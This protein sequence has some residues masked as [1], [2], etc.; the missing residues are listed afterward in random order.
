VDEV[1]NLLAQGVPRDA[2][3]F[4]ALGYRHVLANLDNKG[5]WEDT[6]RVI[7][8]DTR[9]YAKRQLTWFRR[10]TNTTW[11]G[12]TGNNKSIQEEVHRRVQLFVGEFYGV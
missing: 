1:R 2:K 11:F 6:I 4:G 12:G 10:Q 5:A 9:R 8:R 7:Q 3:P